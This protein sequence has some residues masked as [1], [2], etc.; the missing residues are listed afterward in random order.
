MR[1]VPDVS[2]QTSRWSSTAHAGRTLRSIDWALISA[3]L[4]FFTVVVYASLSWRIRHDGA[5]MMYMAFIMDRFGALPYR[6]FF[7]MNMPGSYLAYF[8]IGKLFGYADLGLRIADLSVLTVICC[9]TAAMLWRLAPRAGILAAALVGL[10]YLS[11]GESMSLQR[12]YLALAP[13]ALGVAA[14][15]SA[16][17]LVWRWGLAGLA[18]GVVATIKPH[19]CVGLLPILVYLA[20]GARES[21][22]SRK[23]VITAGAAGFAAFLLPVAATIA[24]LAWAGLFDEFLHSLGYLKYYAAIT[25]RHF[26][27]DLSARPSYLL[28][29][30]LRLGGHGAWWTVAW[31]AIAW[32]WF[33]G[34][35]GRAG[36]RI[37]ALFAGMLLVYTVYPTV[38]GQFWRYHWLPMNF[39]IV[40]SIPMLLVPQRRATHIAAQLAPRAALLVALVILCNI[41]SGWSNP[42]LAPHGAPKGGRPDA[43]GEFLNANL[44]AGET[45]Q[46]MDWAFVGAT[47]GMLIAEARPAT[48]F[49]YTFHFYHH[50][51]SPYIKDLRA[52]YLEAFDRARPAF[53]I[54]ARRGRQRGWVL[55]KDTSPSFRAAQRQLRRRYVPVLK[56]DLYTLWERRSRARARGVEIGNSDRRAEKDGA[57][58]KI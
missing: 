23:A 16:L 55:G 40:A 25:G 19:A 20:A 8:L 50:V 54:E 3:T 51:S 58:G 9:A 7:D 34:D 46:P 27:I 39:W 10:R 11:F 14:A 47:H 43:I 29:N 17:P 36:R 49:L 13:I 5:I 31:L 32:A 28:E 18:F 44:R 24:W 42:Y 15:T 35:V 57:T 53:V 26:T 38:S 1:Y 33:Q 52:E 45:V 2:G 48:R 30:L 21:A 56:A 6:D 12:E 4:V 37:V 41:P 22:G